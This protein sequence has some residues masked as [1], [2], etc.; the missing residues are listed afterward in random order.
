M[1]HA[2]SLL[3]YS[4]SGGS[5]DGHH[6]RRLLPFEFVPPHVCT[7]S[8]ECAF[9][10]ERLRLQWSY[11]E[12]FYD[13]LEWTVACLVSLWDQR[14]TGGCVQHRNI[15]RLCAVRS[16]SSNLL[17]IFFVSFGEGTVTTLQRLIIGFLPAKWASSIEEESRLWIL[18]C[19]CGHERS[20]W[21]SGS[22][23]WKAAGNPR[24]YLRCPRCGQTSW[25]QMYRRDTHTR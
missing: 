17:H 25:H 7:D 15:R 16:L 22:I 11:S 14:F 12:T 2:L 19:P 9:Q 18:R 3:Q 4:D 20:V 21:E 24:Q 1:A 6:I 13:I 5:T 10:T 23:R 8:R